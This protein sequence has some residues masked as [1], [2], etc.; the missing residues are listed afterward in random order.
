MKLI[1]LIKNKFD[2]IFRFLIYL[3][4][5]LLFRNKTV[6]PPVNKSQIKRVLFLRY[7]KIGDMVITLPSIDFVKK[8]IPDVEIDVLATPQNIDIIRNDTRINNIYVCENQKLKLIKQAIKIRKNNY[9]LIFAFVFYKTT[10]GGLIANLAGKRKSIKVTIEHKNRKK[11]YSAF[12]NLLVPSELFIH[13]KC[14]IEVL[15]NIVCYTLGTEYDSKKI[16]QKIYLEDTHILK[17]RKFINSLPQ[18]QFILLNLSAGHPL[19]EWSKENY[20]NLLELLIKDYP[21]FYFILISSP[22]EY[23]TSISISAHFPEKVFSYNS[24]SILDVVALI[25]YTKIVIS[26][27]TSI[28]HISSIYLKPMVVL[29]SRFSTTFENWKPFGVPFRALQTKEKEKIDAI[30]PLEVYYAFKSLYEETEVKENLPL[31]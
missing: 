28:V 1:E 7:D 9:N 13:S 5:K 18:G 23:S 22:S 19:R 12:F 29:Y 6:A 21:S 30:S 16:Y 31:A 10:L 20:I 26:P 14:M 8:T 4:F 27:D 15:F 3:L 2:I 24:S 17:A 11:I 25:P